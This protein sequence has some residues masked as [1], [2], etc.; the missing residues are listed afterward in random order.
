MTSLFKSKRGKA[1]ESGLLQAT[2]VA[3]SV[4]RPSPSPSTTEASGTTESGFSSGR[5]GE[6][7][8][9][10]Y[11]GLT[12]IVQGLYDCSDMFLPL[13]TAAGIFLTVSG[14]A[15]VR[16]DPGGVL[17]II[18][19]MQRV[20]A[21]REELEELEAKLKS[22]LS[23]VETYK[24]HGGIL[25][26][27]SRIERFC[28]RVRSLFL[29]TSLTFCCFQ[30]YCASNGSGQ[31]LAK[32]F[33]LDAD[34]RGDERC[35]QNNKGLPKHEHFMRHLPGSPSSLICIHLLTVS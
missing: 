8:S 6:V 12:A 21:N 34:R 33:P 9:A 5:M 31:Q 17:C 25:A 3:M 1:L 18:L 13:K 27:Y 23:T 14:I 20:S 2:G 29:P 10:A 15:E 35:R 32:S 26:L 24:R 11:A 4:G 30:K 19:S 28:E 22:I 7:S 16:C